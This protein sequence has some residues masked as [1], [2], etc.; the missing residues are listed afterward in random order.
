MKKLGPPTGSSAEYG[1]RLGALVTERLRA[2]GIAIP[3][4]RRVHVNRTLRKFPGFPSGLASET[5]ES[6]VERHLR[7]NLDELKPLFEGTR[8]NRTTY[9]R[10]IGNMIPDLIVELPDGSIIVWDLTSKTVEEH[11]AKTLLYAHLASVA[12]GGSLIRIGENYWKQFG[13]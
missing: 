9:K 1:T 8:R 12:V 13:P 7:Y 4:R 11:L 2:E 5:I 10:R 3:G 6:F